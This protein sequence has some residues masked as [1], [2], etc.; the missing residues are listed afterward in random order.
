MAESGRVIIPKPAKSGLPRT[1]SNQTWH[2]P[3]F[4]N[5]LVSKKYPQWYAGIRP[6]SRRF[7]PK[8]G[9][10]PAFFLSQGL[11]DLGHI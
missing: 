9:F 5:P 3:D 2:L 8:R 7:C 1:E 10:I 11:S 6:P 4:G